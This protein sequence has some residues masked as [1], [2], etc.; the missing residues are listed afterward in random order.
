MTVHLIT[1]SELPVNQTPTDCPPPTSHAMMTDFQ[2]DDEERGGPQGGYSFPQSCA[3]MSEDESHTLGILNSKECHRLNSKECH[4]ISGG[5]RTLREFFQSRNQAGEWEWIE[6]GESDSQTAVF[7]RLL[8]VC[9]WHPQWSFEDLTAWHM[10]KPK[11][12]SLAAAASKRFVYSAEVVAVKSPLPECSAKECRAGVVG[13]A[14]IGRQTAASQQMMREYVARGWLEIHSKTHLPPLLSNIVSTKLNISW[15]AV[16]GNE[17][18]CNEAETEQEKD[19]AAANTTSV[20]VLTEELY[21]MLRSYRI[22]IDICYMTDDEH[23][24]PIYL[25]RHTL[26]TLYLISISVRP[27]DGLDCV[28][29][30]TDWQ[31]FQENMEEYEKVTHSFLETNGKWRL[32]PNRAQ[33]IAHF[34]KFWNSDVNVLRNRE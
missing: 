34:T 30:H 9:K 16:L 27:L 22:A 29:N 1:A 33:V 10:A 12:E 26:F 7:I 20:A 25:D 13:R 15:K 14:G 19:A 24:R 3:W 31:I 23:P 6:D 5:D 32:F 18:L 2:M 21:N 11:E 28:M 17:R 4:V 8:P